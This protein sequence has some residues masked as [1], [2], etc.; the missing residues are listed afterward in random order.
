[1]SRVIEQVGEYK[2]AY[3]LDHILGYFFQVFN[4][5]HDDPIMDLDGLS[6]DELKAMARNY[7]VLVKEDQL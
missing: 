4:S 1:M 5:S 6:L 3:G 2:V 7:G